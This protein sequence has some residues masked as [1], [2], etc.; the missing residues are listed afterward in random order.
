MTE[1]PLDLTPFAALLNG[2]GLVYWAIAAFGL[3]LAWRGSDRRRTRLLRTI[4]VA[5][6]FSFI[7]GGAVLQAYK[8]RARLDESML[9]FKERCKTAGEKITRTADNVDGVVWMKWRESNEKLHELYDDQFKA[10]DPYGRD[11]GGEE[12][13]YQLLRA[14]SGEDVFPE[15]AKLHANG[16]RFVET[17]DPRDGHRY[18][19]TATL[20]AIAGVDRAEFE[21]HVRTTGR[22]AEVGGAFLALNRKPIDRFEA[23]YGITWDD[24]S[25]HEDRLHWI[26]GGSI[27]L[28]DLQTNEVVAK[29]VGYLIDTGQG[30]TGGFRSPWG[31]AKLNAPRCPTV[32]AHTKEFSGR[33][34]QSTR[35]GE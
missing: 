3:W 16:Y 1:T 7:P 33:I 30:G 20:K 13:I 34:I 18:R 12:C 8:A 24:I 21:R 15:A 32:D 4:A 2:L 10:F 27:T 6:V 17:V 22:G 9:L 29:R 31:W 11:C 26:A 28:I 23:R 14:S 19:Y 5:L 35:R 25:T